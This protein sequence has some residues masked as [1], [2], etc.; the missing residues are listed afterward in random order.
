[1]TIEEKYWPAPMM[2][3]V[4]LEDD[5]TEPYKSMVVPLIFRLCPA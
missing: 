4:T 5:R 3:D 2:S 1:M